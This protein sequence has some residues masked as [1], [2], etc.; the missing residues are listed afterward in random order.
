MN[1][2]TMAASGQA[3]GAQNSEQDNDLPELLTSTVVESQLM[4]RTSPLQPLHADRIRLLIGIVVCLY[5]FI[6]SI[7][8][9]DGLLGDPDIWWHIK[10]GAWISNNGRLPTTDPFSFSFAG[11]P[12]IAKEWLAQLIYWKAFAIYGWGGVLLLGALALAL[13]A[14]AIYGATSEW[15]NPALA[16]AI[17]L[18]CLFVASPAI[19][20]RPHLLTLPI[21]A[22]WTSSLF[23]AS[24]RETAPRFL[25]LA[26][27]VLWAN[28]HAAF[29][30]G[31]VIALFAFLDFLER[32]HFQRRKETAFWL[33]FLVLCPLVTLCHPY[34]YRAILATWS[35][36][37]P[38]DVVDQI[39][40]WQ[41]FNAQ[42][43]WMQTA[44]LLG[45]MVAT[46]VSGFRLGIARASLLTLLTYLFLT[47]VRYAFFLF[48]VMAIVIASSV[49][50]QCPSLS[51]SHWRQQPADRSDRFITRHLRAL[52]F[53]ICG[54]FIAAVGLVTMVLVVE[55]PEK[56]SASAAIAFAKAQ[57]ITGP[58]FNHHNFGGALIFNDIPTFID[59]R[60]DQ[61]FRGSFVREYMY[62]PL[63]VKDM[64]STLE[65]YKIL[66]SLLPPEDPRVAL[67]NELPG[68]KKIYADKFAVIHQRQ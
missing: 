17:T 18:L 37:G 9:R 51:S 7:F 21:M 65:T 57:G 4:D 12:W 8:V 5:W 30:M 35:L 19:I 52:A 64:T 14:G 45:L 40:E 36:V 42:E 23:S 15:L 10:T 66:W 39:N 22:L 62:G 25:T 68:W 67:L 59:G 6:A 50:R 20:I 49:A 43:N 56:T 13:A 60:T 54:A 31:F 26:L 38:N 48:P 11:Q 16:A 28:L 44:A 32:T 61:L 46:L 29:T 58:V 33:L 55:P 41:P 24:E 1:S 47:H 34:G 3:S 2:V 63:N 27:L 53:G